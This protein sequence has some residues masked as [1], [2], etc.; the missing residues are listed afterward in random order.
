MSGPRVDDTSVMNAT[1]D[2]RGLFVF[3]IRAFMVFMTITITYCIMLW[4]SKMPGFSFFEQNEVNFFL[5]H[6]RNVLVLTM[7]GTMI[8]AI[9]VNKFRARGRARKILPR[10][11]GWFEA[12][13]IIMTAIVSLINTIRGNT[14]YPFINFGE[15]TFFFYR[16]PGLNA[17][18][19]MIVDLNVFL[20]IAYVVVKMAVAIQSVPSSISHVYVFNR[21]VHESLIGIIWVLIA[22]ILILYGDYFDEVLGMLY[23]VF[24]AFLIGRDYQDVKQLK[25]IRDLKEKKENTSQ[26]ISKN[27]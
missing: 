21:R 12:V 14:F 22:A 2:N 5:H 16:I 20:L 13:I 11:W 25:F 4:L 7:G 23:L 8:I 10:Q 15:A 1:G 24:G 3:I 6:F 19:N 27:E 26:D 9:I 17:L 18:I